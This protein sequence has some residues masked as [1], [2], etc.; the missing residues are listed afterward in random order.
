MDTSVKT[1][2]GFG[3]ER[4][5]SDFRLSERNHYSPKEWESEK[6][7]RSVSGGES[8]SCRETELERD[9]P[10]PMDKSKY[11]PNWDSI[12]N[13][14]KEAAG[15]KCEKC[16]LQCR[17]PGYKFDTHKRTLTVAQIQF[18]VSRRFYGNV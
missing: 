4:R 9:H 17:F 12:A 1:C 3:L 13:E 8:V 7:G 15:W 6:H 2:A 16:K 14:V 5:E 11:P 18:I 10:M